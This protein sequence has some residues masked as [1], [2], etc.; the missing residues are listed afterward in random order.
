MNRNNPFLI[1][2]YHAIDSRS[3][4][5]SVSPGQFRWQMEQLNANGLSGISLAQA[6]EYFEKTGEFRQ[7]AVVLTFD[8]G[9]R[10]VLEHALPIM[11][12]LGFNA[13]LFLSTNMMGMNALQARAAHADFDR[14]VL[15]WDQAERLVLAGF[16]I[17]SHTVNHPDLR[18]LPPAELE[19]ELV[20][21]K[22]LLEQ[23]LQPQVDALAYPYGHYNAAVLAAAARHYRNACTTRLGRCSQQ[24]ELFKLKRVDAYYFRQPQRFLKLLN[25]GLAGWLQFRQ[26]MRELKQVAGKI[27]RL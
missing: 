16:E 24:T 8:D 25:G 1:L 18:T 21:S 12:D 27:R 15:S 3:A 17:G 11:A 20:Q 6:F 22:A 23:R 5:I 10:S 2:T 19:H 7:D 26:Q 13:T 9:Y 4:V 14:D